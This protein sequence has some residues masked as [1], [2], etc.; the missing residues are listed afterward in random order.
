MLV[1]DRDLHE[2][3]M[4]SNDGDGKHNQEAEKAVTELLSSEA[5]ICDMSAQLSDSN[6]SKPVTIL[7]VDDS[8]LMRMGLTRV[9]NSIAEFRVVGESGDG[10]KAVSAAMTL[11]PDVVLMDIGLPGIDGIEAAR[12]IKEK[13][14][15][16]RVI[17]FTGHDDANETVAAFGAGADAYVLKDLSVD[18]LSNAI[19][20]VMS[21]FSWID[22]RV[23][24]CLNHNKLNPSLV[25]SAG[26]VDED[27]QLLKMIEEGLSAQDTA[28]RLNIS[29]DVVRIRI[30]KLIEKLFNADQTHKS[31]DKVRQQLAS[32]FIDSINNSGGALQRKRLQEQLIADE[33]QGDHIVD[34]RYK[35]ESVIGKGGMGIVYSGLHLHM[36]RKVAIKVLYPHSSNDLKCIKRFQQES[37]AASAL[38]HPN[39]ATVYDFGLTEEG[40]PY[41]VMDYV[42]GDSLDH[43]IRNKGGLTLHQYLDVFMQVCDALAATHMAG[44]VHCD[45]KT[46]N[47]MVEGSISV[48]F[49]AKLVD[50]GLAM[51]M[52]RDI[53][54]QQ[55]QTESFEVQGSPLYMSPE[56]CQGKKLDFR[57]DIYSLGCIMYE[58]F[59][60][61]PVFDC[62]T[63]YQLFSKHIYEAPRSFSAANPKVRVPDKLESIIMRCLEKRLDARYVSASAIKNDLRNVLMST[64][65]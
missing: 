18:N 62:L 36:Q 4:S 53:D 46:S 16:T 42:D 3:K 6:Q 19:K 8:D 27:I 12:I 15:A 60:G 51:A 2:A 20:S 64:V 28:E 54:I 45:L 32:Q 22:S 17:M 40:H 57:T 50:F 33:A 30:G 35:I 61:E 38:N 58:A 24:H 37:R 39:I 43:W 23:A 56:Q 31:A 48:G 52:P 59:T 26:F 29:V 21:G 41:L 34:G 55:Q 5:G 49:T 9:L 11:R 13:L 44:L 14:P 65:V 63:P 1:P 7:I 10:Y 25:V 47:I